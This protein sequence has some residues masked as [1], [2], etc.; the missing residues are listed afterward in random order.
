MDGLKAVP[1][2]EFGF[3]RK[4]FSRA[5]I[6]SKNRKRLEIKLFQALSGGFGSD[7]LGEGLTKAD[8]R[9][10]DGTLDLRFGNIEQT[11][12]HGRRIAFHIAQQKKQAL[13]GG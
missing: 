2:K 5:L 8:A 9:R 10:K 6:Q 3:F 7:L 12:D 11:A 4:L 1:F 13:V